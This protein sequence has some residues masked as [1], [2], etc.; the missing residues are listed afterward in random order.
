M[1]DIINKAIKV[2]SEGGLVVYPTDTLY[3]LGAS[4]FKP[5]AV[6]KVYKIKKRPLEFYLP[7]AVS[8]VEGINDIAVMNSTAKKI[9]EKFMPGAITIVLEK[10]KVVN[11]IVAGDKIAV[12]IPDN[13]IA[14]EITSLA[15]PITATSANIH[16]GTAPSDI[17]TAKK[18]LGDNVELYIDGGKLNGVPSTIVDVSGGDIKIIREGAIKTERFYE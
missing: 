2:L 4:I 17:G 6:R 15:G 9:A 10:K 5:D 14:L 8:N 12:R 11:E 1:N 16:N 3:A 18:Q 7:V 13:P